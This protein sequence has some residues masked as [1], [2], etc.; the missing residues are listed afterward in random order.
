MMRE[1][2]EDE[3][4]NQKNSQKIKNIDLKKKMNQDDI[5]KI[6][7]Q[8]NDMIKYEYINLIQNQ[9]ESEHLLYLLSDPKEK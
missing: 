1:E 2:T 9:K 3:G 5:K 4:G 7:K 8:E 6:M